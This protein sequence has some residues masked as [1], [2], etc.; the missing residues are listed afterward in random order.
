MLRKLRVTQYE[1]PY[2]LGGQV[3]FCRGA[4][5]ATPV[6][7]Q[8]ANC[9]TPRERVRFPL[10]NGS[11]SIFISKLLTYSRKILSGNT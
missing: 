4:W 8:G 1:E 9:E 7:T 6:F 5:A 3:R 11:D 10:E 2:A